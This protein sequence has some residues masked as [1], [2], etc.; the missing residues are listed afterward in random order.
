MTREA[1]ELQIST[2]SAGGESGEGGEGGD[3][4]GEGGEGCD[5]QLLQLSLQYT[6]M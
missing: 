6:S 3:E 5:G 2:A 1:Y 4:G